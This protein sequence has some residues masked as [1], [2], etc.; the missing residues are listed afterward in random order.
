MKTSPAE[1]RVFTG[2]FSVPVHAVRVIATVQHNLAA[3]KLWAV[4]DKRDGLFKLDDS[5]YCLIEDQVCSYWQ[6]EPIISDKEKTNAD[7]S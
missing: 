7:N 6:V 2:I 5:T 3:T 4:N 1:H